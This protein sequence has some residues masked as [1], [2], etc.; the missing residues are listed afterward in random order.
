MADGFAPIATPV[1]GI[2]AKVFAA[3]IR[4]AKKAGDDAKAAW[5]ERL[6]RDYVECGDVF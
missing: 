2:S 4:D 1:L 5:L 6:W 3:G